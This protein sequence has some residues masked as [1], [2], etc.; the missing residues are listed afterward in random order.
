[1]EIGLQEG[2]DTLAWFRLDEGWRHV[3]DDSVGDISLSSS[4]PPL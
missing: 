1:M 4:G 2:V 3:L